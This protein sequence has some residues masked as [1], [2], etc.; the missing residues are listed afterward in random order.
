M[1][2]TLYVILT[3]IICVC[4]SVPAI[5]E[6][7]ERSKIH[8]IAGFGTFSFQGEKGA[9]TGICFNDIGVDTQLCFS[10]NSETI[11][12]VV[13]PN[14]YDGRLLPETRPRPY[15]KFEGLKVHYFAWVTPKNE[16]LMT[17]VVY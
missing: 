16:C 13:S 14:K 7:K 3:M 17:L 15:D 6:E 4:V 11:Y 9:Y 12:K 8:K 5:A 1:K 2:K 10:L